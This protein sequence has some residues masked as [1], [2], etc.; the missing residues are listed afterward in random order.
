LFL[1]VPFLLFL[2]LLLFWAAGLRFR[3]VQT[4]DSGVYVCRARLSGPKR[5]NIQV[6]T[7]STL[8]IFPERSIIYCRLPRLTSLLTKILVFTLQ[9]GDNFFLNFNSIVSRMQ[10]SVGVFNRIFKLL[11]SPGMDSKESLPPAYVACAGIL[12]NLWG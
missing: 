10:L 7:F 1:A 4:R 8:L 3:A 11:R 5:R 12:N 9:I 2:P 6:L